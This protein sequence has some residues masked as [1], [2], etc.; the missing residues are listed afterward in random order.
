MDE[1]FEKL[2]GGEY[3]RLQIVQ[4]LLQQPALLIL[5]EATSALDA[6]SEHKVKHVLNQLDCTQITVSH[7]LSTIRDA[8][9]ILVLKDGAIA[10]QGRH[11]ELA[12]IEGSPYQTILQLEPS[13]SNIQHAPN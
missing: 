12:A 13:S 3:Q 10:Q 5:D 7:R 6:E 11:D 1:A 8:D 9:Q 2:S 4:A